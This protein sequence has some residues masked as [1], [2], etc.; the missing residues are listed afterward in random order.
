MSP[1]SAKRLA[2]LLVALLNLLLLAAIYFVRLRHGPLWK[3]DC[4]LVARWSINSNSETA[5]TAQVAITALLTNK[6]TYRIRLLP[7]QIEYEDRA[8]AVTKGLD[9]LWI[10]GNYDVFLPPGGV[11]GL[12]FDVPLNTKRVRL[13]ATYARQWG[14]VRQA[15]GRGT[16]RLPLRYLPPRS[17]TWLCKNGL[18]YPPYLFLRASPWMLNP[19]AQRTETSHSADV[20][21][22]SVGAAG[23]RP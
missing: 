22:E 6:N 18:V 15:L 13:L 23:F 5:F 16:S 7:L 17:Y 19:A 21:N 4:D 14:A 11:A 2:T 12:Q 3:S 1:L 8:G 10:G 20:L 9:H